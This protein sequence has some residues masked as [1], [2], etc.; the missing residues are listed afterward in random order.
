MYIKYMKEN[1]LVKEL[2]VKIGDKVSI[3]GNEGFVTEVIKGHETEWNGKEY[4][5]IEGSDYAHVRVH[6]TGEL[7][8][9]GQYQDGVYGGFVVLD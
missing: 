3:Q 6:F 8:S 4:V 9:W 1:G 2:N 5:K 7:A